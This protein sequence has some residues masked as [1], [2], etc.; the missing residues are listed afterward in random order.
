[1]TY[2]FVI[3]RSLVIRN[4]LSRARYSTTL[5][6]VCP[7]IA[8]Y[9]LIAFP[10]SRQIITPKLAFLGFP[11]D[12]ASKLSLWNP[13]GGHLN[14]LEDTCFACRCRIGSEIEDF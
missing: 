1:M 7:R 4:T 13:C 3:L 12:A 9:I 8:S 5:F 2:S 10:L 11:L 14:L 6:V